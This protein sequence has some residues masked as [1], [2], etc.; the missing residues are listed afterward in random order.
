MATPKLPTSQC[1]MASNASLYSRPRPARSGSYRAQLPVRARCAARA[2]ARE[3]GRRQPLAPRRANTRRSA[4]RAAC[5][6]DPPAAAT[7]GA[8]ANA[9]AASAH[10]V[11][12]EPGGA[13]RVRRR[14]RSNTVFVSNCT[15]CDRRRQPT[16]LERRDCKPDQL[17]R[18]RHRERQRQR[19]DHLVMVEQ[20]RLVVRRRRQLQRRGRQRRRRRRRRLG[21]LQLGPLGPQSARRERG[22]ALDVIS[23]R[24]HVQRL[25]FVQLVAA[26]DQDAQ[27]AGQ[28]AWVAR[29]V[30]DALGA[31]CRAGRAGRRGGSRRGQGPAR[32]RRARR[33]A[34]GRAA[35]VLASTKR[36]LSTRA[37]LCAAS[38]HRRSGF[39]DADHF[40]H[41]RRQQQRERAHA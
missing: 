5:Q 11:F 41:Q 16:S 20:R 34:A 28:G 24:K 22:H 36:T 33:S 29:D 10:M 8:R 14:S 38:L 40:A 31:R 4:R 15:D 32:P 39:F 35:S 3:T 26:V 27:V 2:G 37:A 25:D 1:W 17:R 23:L 7:R 13:H 12:T 19:L 18:H 30:H 9:G 6:P 21:Q